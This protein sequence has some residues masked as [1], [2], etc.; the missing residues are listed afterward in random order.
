MSASLSFDGAQIAVIASKGDETA[1]IYVARIDG[2]TWQQATHDSWPKYDLAWSPDGTRI[3][4]SARGEDTNGDGSINEDDAIEIY[5]ISTDG[6]DLQQITHNEGR[7]T[8]PGWSPNGEW[9]VYRLRTKQGRMHIDG[10][11]LLDLKTGESRELVPG[12]GIAAPVSWSPDGCSIAIAASS[13]NEEELWFGTDIYV[14]DIETGSR[15]KLTD[16]RRYTPYRGGDSGG[17]SRD[18][19]H[20]SQLTD[21]SQFGQ[22]PLSWRP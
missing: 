9:M 5:T 19:S 16:T 11:Y 8:N 18:G 15:V 2:D 13:G 12:G 21:W 4:F 1:E 14:R 22:I 7:S 6:S 17:V 3:A 10:L 20:L